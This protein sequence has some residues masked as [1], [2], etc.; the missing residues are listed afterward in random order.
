MPMSRRTAPSSLFRQG[1][2]LLTALPR[3][4][5]TIWLAAFLFIAVLVGGWLHDT[6]AMERQMRDHVDMVARLAAEQASLAM[7][8]ADLA[9]LAIQSELRPA[10]F[11]APN[12]LEPRRGALRALLARAQA[13]DAGL[14]HIALADAKGNVIAALPP[15]PASST[16]QQYR[17]VAR[18]IAEGARSTGAAP[19]AAANADHDERILISAMV[20]Q[21]L[22]DARAVR[23]VRPVAR[24]NGEVVGAIVAHVAF[25]WNLIAAEPPG[26]PGNEF[27]ALSDGRHSLITGNGPRRSFFA[28]LVDELTVKKAIA[29]ES[30]PRQF[31]S[32]LAGLDSLVATRRVPRY[33]LFVMYGRSLEPQQSALWRELLVIALA[34]IGALAVTAGVAGSIRRGAALTRQLQRTRAHLEQSNEALRTALAATELL[35]AKD[36]LTGLWNRRSF[37]Q[38]L[39]EAIAHLARHEGEL[40]LLII[41]ID[42]FKD[43]ND[44]H[45]HL[46]GD[47]VLRRFADLLGERLR[48]N[49]VAA[50]WGGEEFVVLADGAVLE[51]ASLLAEQIRESALSETFPSVGPVTVSIGIA[52][53]RRGETP[54][55]LLTRAD[56]ALYEAKRGGRNRVSSSG[57]PAAASAEYRR[58]PGDGRKP[59]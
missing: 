16:D 11:T 20:G 38:R 7:D 19:L 29:G 41:D 52:D 26:Y 13:R 32:P 51:N 17:D 42:H 8:K 22:A 56:D 25:D 18:T 1:F 10:D 3:S 5:P 4:V 33:P 21:P 49:D 59:S 48:Q 46:V 44:R 34:A 35:A 2:A 31:Q 54:D 39:Q 45:G 40:S 57:R 28:R 15:L 58:A 23:L 24:S 43:I 36:Q 12:V 9:L 53:Y 47:D 50:R 14:A 27:L 6:A 37:D 55:Q 30:G